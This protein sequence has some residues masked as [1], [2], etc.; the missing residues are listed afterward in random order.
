MSEV[1]GGS[2]LCRGC[3]IIFL[4]APSRKDQCHSSSSNGRGGSWHFVMQQLV[5]ISPYSGCQEEWVTLYLTL[6]A[7]LLCSLP[8]TLFKRETARSLHVTAIL[9]L[10]TKEDGCLQRYRG[11]TDQSGKE[12]HMILAVVQGQG[13]LMVHS[14]KKKKG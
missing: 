11:R 2:G 6:P 4:P 12:E 3:S 1:T 8:N 5:R 13:L 14:A 9:I 10:V 7:P